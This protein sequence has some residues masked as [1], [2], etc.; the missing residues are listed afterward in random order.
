MRCK[1]QLTADQWAAWTTAIF[2]AIQAMVVIGAL[3]VAFFEWRGHQ[4]EDAVKRREASTKLF[5]DQPD[6]VTAAR[7]TAKRDKTCRNL[8]SEPVDAMIKFLCDQY[9]TD[10]ASNARTPFERIQPLR[11]YLAKIEL[12]MQN[13]ICDRQLTSKLF[14]PDVQLLATF[15]QSIFSNIVLPAPSLPMSAECNVPHLPKK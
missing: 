3:L 6:A 14:C 11:E 8:T 2:T 7:E 15:D 12:C 5:L 13:E 4:H 10:N 9:E 1:F